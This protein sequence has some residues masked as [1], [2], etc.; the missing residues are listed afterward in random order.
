MGRGEALS[1]AS[2]WQIVHL[3]QQGLTMSNVAERVGCTRNSVYKW[4]GRYVAT[5]ATSTAR[6]SGR[7]R[8]FN[9]VAEDTA[10]EMLTAPDSDGAN[11]VTQRLRV[12]G[13]IPVTVHRHTT[14]RAARRAAER[15]GVRLWCQQGKPPKAMTASTK[16]QRLAFATRHLHRDWPRVMF[17]DRKKFLFRYPGS[18][19]RHVRWLAGAA[20]SNNSGV[21]QPNHPQCLNVYAGIT[22]YGVTAVHVV[23]GSSKYTTH[24]TNKQGKAAKNITTSQY[25]EVLKETLLPE[26]RRLFSTQGIS[27][28]TL[29]QDNDPTH[30]CA[31]DEVKNWNAVKGSSVQL[32]TSW[33]PNSPDLNLIENIWGWVQGEVDKKGCHSFEDWSKAVISTIAA[34]PKQHLTNLYASMHKRLTAVVAN[35]GGP[36]KY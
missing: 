23:A 1:E 30:R 32:L 33:P 35:G 6:K 11:Q 27:T 10:L 19:V 13:C 17:T 20:N 16:R 28:W 8:T 24:H 34:V 21:N 2:R 22:K 14:V 26:G 29:Q 4:W 36:T 7:K 15:A 9:D 31:P 12:E 5:Q 25:R 3:C 18:K